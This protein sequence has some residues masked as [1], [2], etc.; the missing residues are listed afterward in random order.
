MILR[1][2][3]AFLVFVP[4]LA[5]QRTL[6]VPAE[7]ASINAA[8]AAA[9]NGD[10]ILV[11]PGEYRE[12][13]LI[14]GKN[15]VIR[16]EEG[17]SR[18][19]IRGNGNQPVLQIQGTA[20]TR[21]TRIEGF[22]VTGG[23]GSNEG[24]GFLVQSGA[25][26]VISR[27][28]IEN[29]TYCSAGGGVACG[30]ASPRIEFNLIRNNRQFACS[31]GTGGAGVSVRGSSSAE[32]VGNIIE[33][34]VNQTSSGGG[35]GLFASGLTLVQGNL[36]RRNQAVFAG[37]IYGANMDAELLIQNIVVENQA[38]RGAGVELGGGAT[39]VR[40]IGNT[41][42]NN[43]GGS[44]MFV[45]QLNSGFRFHNNLIAG[46]H[47]TALIEA[48]RMP[49][50]TPQM[51]HNLLYND[52]GPILDRFGPIGGVVGIQGNISAD[53]L[54]VDAAYGDYHIRLD[55]P[56]RDAGTQTVPG[57]LPASDFWGQPRIAGGPVFGQV[58]IGADEDNGIRPYGRGC[59][60]SSPF[61]ALARTSGGDPR[62]GNASF[63][64]ELRS[65]RPNANCAIFI[66]V[67]RDQWGNLALPWNLASLGMP[68][69]ELLTSI[70]DA[71]LAATDAAGNATLP[72]PLP[73]NPA[74]QGLRFPVQWLIAGPQN[75][76]PGDL[77]DAVLIELR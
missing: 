14:Q 29:N 74:F 50:T 55:S 25:A 60:Q 7:Q 70:N 16:S 43:V 63:A 46:S 41:I 68:R 69:C 39:A 62:L 56:A 36:V 21:A 51:F 10:T 17:P 32:I 66:G 27:N 71:R 57:G 30:F 33:D 19:T 48:S 47:G 26:P 61:L 35:S 65:A 12:S 37:G 2:A 77:S 4:A 44:A 38:S 42:A 73:N 45:F 1:T 40:L 64:L 18:T 34:N 75:Y 24:G 54:F 67:S 9:Q 20:I 13:L 11:A 49:S 76:I 58:D 52:A 31:G 5:A 3:A 28:V 15:V 8:Y 22:T 72:Y 6:R 53:P 23:R 59:D